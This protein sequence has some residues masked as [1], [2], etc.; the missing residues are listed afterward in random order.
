MN[1]A[2]F[3]LASGLLDSQKCESFHQTR[4]LQDFPHWVAYKNQ[5][6]VQK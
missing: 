6:P 2:L 5:K 4:L 1:H 3:A